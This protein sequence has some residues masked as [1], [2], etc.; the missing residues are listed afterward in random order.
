MALETLENE[1][2]KILED[3]EDFNFSDLIRHCRLAIGI[4]QRQVSRFI[5]THA[6]RVQ[7]L[8]AG[9]FIDYP[10]E[11]ELERLSKLYNI[12]LKILEA[13][14]FDHMRRRRGSKSKRCAKNKKRC[15]ESQED[16]DKRDTDSPS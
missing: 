11:D 15:D 8:E 7:H 13:K 2:N 10:K 5:K 1:I 3:V 6:H 12:S 9:T 16:C 4:T 14:A